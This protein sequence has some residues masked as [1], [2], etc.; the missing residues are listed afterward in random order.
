MHFITRFG[1]RR[2]G[3]T[4]SN[5]VKS[6][7]PD[8]ISMESLLSLPVEIW[9]EIFKYYLQPMSSFDISTFQPFQI[10]ALQQS[11]YHYGVEGALSQCKMERASLMLVSRAWKSIVNGYDVRSTNEVSSESEERIKMSLTYEIWKR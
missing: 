9:L 11:L 2:A 7:S 3:A 4:E 6:D 5:K 1:Q 8:Q 10:E